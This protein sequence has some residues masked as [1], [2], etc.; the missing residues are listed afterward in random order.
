MSWVL[1]TIN[2]SP[3]GGHRKDDRPR[4]LIIHIVDND[5]NVVAARPGD[6][7][8]SDIVVELADATC[9]GLFHDQRAE[10]TGKLARFGDVIDATNDIQAV[11]GAQFLA[12]R[13]IVNCSALRD[14]PT[15]ARRSSAI[16]RK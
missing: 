13:K 8:P 2:P 16:L 10:H 15:N 6:G 3:Q 9:E 12:I 5:D 4:R 11:G 1:S 7:N 14:V